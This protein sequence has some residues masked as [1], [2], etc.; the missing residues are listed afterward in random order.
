MSSRI[1]GSG[2]LFARGRIPPAN[3]FP[4]GEKIACVWGVHSELGGGKTYEGCFEELRQGRCIASLREQH[5]ASGVPAA[6]GTQPM[7]ILASSRDTRIIFGVAHL[8]DKQ[9]L[10]SFGGTK[11]V[12]GALKPLPEPLLNPLQK[13]AVEFRESLCKIGDFGN[14]WINI[15]CSNLS[16]AA[17]HRR[18]KH[19]SLEK[20]FQEDQRRALEAMVARI[21]RKAPSS[22][23]GRDPDQDPALVGTKG[24]CA[25]GPAQKRKAKETEREKEQKRTR[26]AL[27]KCAERRNRFRNLVR[28]CF[29]AKGCRLE[30][31]EKLERKELKTLKKA[32]LHVCLMF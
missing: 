14:P 15:P 7:I 5:I 20:Q 8:R 31:L 28:K 3:F 19:L 25:R 6:L 21:M 32:F 17:E 24:V 4:L 26:I 16:P 1:V 13:A 23:P 27:A 11:S 22:P 30:A 2:L 29:S 12:S 9:M 10:E 18:E